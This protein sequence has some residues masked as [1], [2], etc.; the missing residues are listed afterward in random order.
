MDQL[1]RDDGRSRRC[2]GRDRRDGDR[3]ATGRS[4]S[5]NAASSRPDLN[6]REVQILK[7]LVNGATNREVGEQLHLSHNTIKFH[8]RQ[9]LEKAGVSNRTELATRAAL[10][11]WV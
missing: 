11:G 3:H 4:V 5:L 2:R 1:P 8:I 10:Q 9:L 6:D 7:L